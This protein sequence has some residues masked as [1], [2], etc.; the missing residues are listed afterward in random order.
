MTEINHVFYV[1][2][3]GHGRSAIYA[4]STVRD[5]LPSGF[6]EVNR[7]RTRTLIKSNALAIAAKLRKPRAR[8]GRR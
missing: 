1:V 2:R 7:P 3:K 6:V 8:R 5:V 4:V